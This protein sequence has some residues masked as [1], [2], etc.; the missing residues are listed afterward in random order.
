M[1]TTVEANL[2]QK[3]ATAEFRAEA[4]QQLFPVARS[5]VSVKTQACDR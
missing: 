5:P 1:A 4:E 2:G 3:N